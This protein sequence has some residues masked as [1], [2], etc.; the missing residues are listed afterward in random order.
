MSRAR[1][2][3]SL[4]RVINFDAMRAAEEAAIKRATPERLRKAPIS[5]IVNKNVQRVIEAPLEMLCARGRLDPDP[6]RNALLYDAGCRYRR[7][8]QASGLSQL[9]AIDYG[10]EVLAREDSEGTH[11]YMGSERSA[12]HRMEIRAARHALGEYL[13]R[14]LDAI[15]IEER[16]PL[17]VGREATR[18]ADRTTAT[19]IAMEVLRAGLTTLAGHWRMLG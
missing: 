5:M 15:V 8:W 7:H 6:R 2:K 17:E 13:A 10:R 14:W 18:Y 16:A 4:P 1:Q 11:P 12:G 9:K 19:A 3:P